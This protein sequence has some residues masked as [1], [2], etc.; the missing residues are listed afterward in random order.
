MW[1]DFGGPYY[2]NSVILYDFHTTTRNL[3]LPTEWSDPSL[4]FFLIPCISIINIPTRTL[5]LT[6]FYLKINTRRKKIILYIIKLKRIFY[7]CGWVVGHKRRTLPAACWCAIP[8]RPGFI[9]FTV[10]G[11]VR[12][13]I[14]ISFSNP[15]GDKHIKVYSQ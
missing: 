4:H 13:K 11:E 9:F 7:S 14:T 8:K 1:L 12:G 6:K 2:N 15:Y 10:Q 3:S 5:Q